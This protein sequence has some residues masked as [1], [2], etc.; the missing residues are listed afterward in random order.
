MATIKLQNGNVILKDGRASCTC[1][2]LEP[3]II[4]YS[5]TTDPAL[6]K[7][8]DECPNVGFPCGGSEN[9]SCSSANVSGFLFSDEWSFIPQNKTP[10]AKIYA[11]AQ[12]DN[13]GN[14]GS[15]VSNDQGSNNCV[16]GTI[17]SDVIDTA[18]LDGNKTK[19]AF[20]V[21][22][23]QHGGPYGLFSAVIEWYWE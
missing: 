21:T 11:G 16:L 17:S 18:I 12:F 2:D 20:S 4:S 14:I 19:I 9:P 1:C 5:Y 7:G 8:F 3:M 13:F 23:A 6:G 22:N 15:A 10:K